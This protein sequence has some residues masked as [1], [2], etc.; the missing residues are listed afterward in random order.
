MMPMDLR[1]LTVHEPWASLIAYGVKPVENRTWASTFMLGK[2]LAIHR[3][4]KV[5]FEGA[6]VLRELGYVRGEVV[7]RQARRKDVVRV[8]ASH[9]QAKPAYLDLTIPVG[10]EWIPLPLGSM[11]ILCT[12]RVRGF[13]HESGQVIVPSGA[14]EAERAHVASIRTHPYFVGPWG[15]VLGDV[16]R[17]AVPAHCPGAQGLWMVTQDVRERIA[18]RE[19]GA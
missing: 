17:L 4:Q 11:S 9:P 1:A 19:A 18:T 16:K 3:G 13:V 8:D 7:Y 12:A 6:E 14:S 10:G 2:R 5:D 15:W